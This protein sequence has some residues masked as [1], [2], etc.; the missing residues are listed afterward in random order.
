M[1][2]KI[3][4]S[5]TGQTP[6]PENWRGDLIPEHITW[7]SELNEFESQNIEKALQ[8]HLFGSSRIN[9]CY[10]EHLNRVHQDMFDDVWKWA[11]KYRNLNLNIGCSK[12]MVPQNVKQLCDDLAF[13]ID[14][15]TYAPQ[16][17][18]IRF[19]HRLVSIHPYINGNGRHARI[20]ADILVKK[21]K[22]HELT[23][24]KRN[25]S[26]E[27]PDRENYISSLQK[28]DQGD[29]SDL[30]KFAGSALHQE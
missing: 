14:N 8:K 5:I 22:A 7:L 23:W 6:L 12:E 28:A 26:K 29:Y 1:K 11:G 24:G 2:K 16:E 13:W 25:L 20:M 30:I 17:I 19:H 15:K 10:P 4:E 3:T 18:A 21:L 27:G 9:P